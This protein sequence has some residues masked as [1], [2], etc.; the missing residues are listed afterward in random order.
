MNRTKIA[1]YLLLIFLAGAIAGGALVL[2]TPETFGLGHRP[3]RMGSPE[4][5]AN[6]I[7]N[8]MKQRLA[9]TE[10]QTPKV[11]P[12]FRAGFAEVRA[13]QEKSIQEVEAVIRKNHEEIAA[14]LTPEQRV[15]LDKMDQERQA[16]FI[17]RGHKPA[18]TNSGSP[19]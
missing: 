2:S 15:E 8:E 16:F 5:F 19:K 3:R 11:E 14:L 6:H 13:I 10:E 4:D 12:V 1:V 7:W 9:L 18:E 17:K